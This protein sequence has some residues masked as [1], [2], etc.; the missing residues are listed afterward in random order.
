MEVFV[1]MEENKNKV[2]LGDGVADTLKQSANKELSEN[3]KLLI[4]VISKFVKEKIQDI[5][6]NK[7]L[8]KKNKEDILKLWADQL[9]EKG[10]IASGYTGLPDDLLIHNLHQEGFLD[11]MYIG[12]V[13][14]MMSLIDNNADRNLILSVRDDIR[15]AIVY[16]N[17]DDREEVIEEF[18]DDKYSLINDLEMKE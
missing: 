3:G 15:D 12:Y 14:A 9:V 1:V 18:K 10:V 13:L 11:G 2:K 7:L 17:Y 4:D 5:D 6:L 16:R 8:N